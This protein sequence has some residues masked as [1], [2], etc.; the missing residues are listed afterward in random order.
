MRVSAQPN[1]KSQQYLDSPIILPP[2]EVQKKIVEYISKQRDA[3]NNLQKQAQIMRTD[4]L[5]EFENE[6]FE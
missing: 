4:A 1:I 6:I 2:L 3:I 5:K